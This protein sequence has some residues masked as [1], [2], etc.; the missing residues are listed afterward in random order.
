MKI[1]HYQHGTARILLASMMVTLS[2]RVPRTRRKS[3]KTINK[4][5]KRRQ[6]DALLLKAFT[7]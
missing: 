1:K 4:I 6:R 7:K 2:P 3:L 5:N